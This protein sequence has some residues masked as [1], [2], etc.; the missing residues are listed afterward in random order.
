M[1][2]AETEKVWNFLQEQPALAGFILGGGSAL[3]LNLRHRLSE[4]LDFVYPEIRLPRQR[5]E[6]LQREAA[7]SGFHFARNDDETA[8]QEFAAS[9][10]ELHDYQQDFLVN[11]KVK[12]SFFAADAALR[13]VL[14]STNEKVR[15]ATLSESFKAKCLVSAVRSK[16]RDWL[17]LYLLLKDHGFS[18]L[19]YRNAFA[20]AGILSQCHTGLARLC[21]GVPGSGDEGYHQMLAN[22]PTLEEIKT[23][24]ISQRDRLEIETAAEA[25]RVKSN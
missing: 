5:L 14:A 21:S 10:L 20:E 16:T 24:F 8:V 6:A 7:S 18:I 4:D 19:D 25:A 1:L 2:P 9:G 12:V 23:F 13:K 17:D 3:A 22:P 15:V 11:Q